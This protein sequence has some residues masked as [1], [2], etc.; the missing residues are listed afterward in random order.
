MSHDGGGET[1]EMRKSNVKEIH[2]LEYL[3]RQSD[4]HLPNGWQDE[5]MVEDMDDGGMGSLTLY[6]PIYSAERA[7]GRQVSE[8][9]FLDKDMTPVIATLYVDKQEH[10]FELDIWKVDYSPLLSLP[11]IRL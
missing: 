6:P 7:F 3:I 9:Q 11:D 5:L 1:K 8:Y 10:L 2:F 4:V